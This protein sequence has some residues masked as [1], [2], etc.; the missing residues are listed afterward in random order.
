VIFLKKHTNQ[1]EELKEL[2]LNLFY[3]YKGNEISSLVKQYNLELKDKTLV[4]VGMGGASFYNKNAS[5]FLKTKNPMDD[6][7]K[8]LVIK[9]L[10][11]NKDEIK[12]IYPEASKLFPLQRLSRDLGISKMSPIGIDIHPRYGLWFS[13]R[14]IFIYPE[15]D[16]ND[17]PQEFISPCESCYTK[18]CT[19][20]NQTFNEAR[21]SCPYK[22]EERYSDEQI[23]FH[24]EQLE[25]NFK[26]LI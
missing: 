10:K 22:N 12:E 17:F 11:L 15:L 16:L 5:T 25:R 19:N 26:S 24:Q 21:L 4:L 23:L 3:A 7:A 20:L 1:I 18:N 2:G 8:D 9:K 6:T 13:F 14:F